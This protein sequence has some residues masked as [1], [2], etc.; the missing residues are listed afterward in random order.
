MDGYTKGS[1]ILI[2]IG[3]T[4]LVAV[5]YINSTIIWPASSALCVSTYDSRFTT[6]SFFN[7]VGVM[8][9][10]AGG[11]VALF[12]FNAIDGSGGDK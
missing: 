9:I 6:L 2:G 12:R 4:I 10:A 8:F 3:I 5:Y 1:I 7:L 11:L